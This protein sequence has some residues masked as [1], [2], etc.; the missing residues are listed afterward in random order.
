MVRFTLPSRVSRLYPAFA[1]VFALSTAV[2]AYAWQ[3]SELE[4][5]HLST[6]SE[7]NIELL[8][9]QVTALSQSTKDD[10]SKLQVQKQQIDQAATQLADL[11]KQYDQASSDLA[12]KESQLKDA[13]SQLTQTA[14]ELND[15]RSHPP[16]FSFQNNST[17]LKNV[18]TKE[19]Q[20]KT[21]ITN[22]YG[23]IQTLYGQPYLL[24]SI[25][26][27][28]VDNF[29]IAGSAGEILISNGPDG[30]SINIH[31]KDFDPN[32]FQ[33]VNTVIHEIIHGFHGLAVFTTSALEEGITVAMTDAVMSRMITDGKLPHFDHLYITLTPAEYATL[34]NSLSIP[35]DNTAF[36]SNSNVA[37]IYQVIG[38]AWYQL[39]LNDPTVFKKINDYYYPHIQKG[40]KADTPLILDAVR[41]AIK[42]VNNQPIATYLAQNSAFNPR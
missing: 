32:E 9:S 13:Q 30:I 34:N 16:L 41:S 10:E 36:Y 8:Q 2:L 14:S 12:T 24:H 29:S 38:M 31:L 1:L 42:T 19:S 28:F 15:L 7:K 39:Y 26:I 25:T 17:S 37:E 21:L 27:T 35:A 5:S 20:I 4:L 6:N 22:A 18:D 40:E 23:Y 11:K 33:D 3:S